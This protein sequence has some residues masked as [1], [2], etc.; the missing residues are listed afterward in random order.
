MSLRPGELTLVAAELTRELQQSVI[1]KVH[2]PTT[3]RVY[4]ELRVPG[5][6]VTLL[7]CSEPNVARVSAVV[8][9]PANPATP[10]AWQ[11]VLR[12][13]LLGVKFRD[14]EALPGRRTLL[15]HVTREGDVP[16][17]RTLVLEL[18]ATPGIALITET[19]RILA[20]SIPFR[21][22][23]RIGATWLVADEQP[24][25]EAPSR[26]A[27][28]QV[29]LRLT[30]AAETLYATKEQQT[31]D[32]ARRAPLVA[33]LKRLARTREKVKAEA[34]RAEQAAKLRSE[35]ELLTHNLFKVVRGQKSVTLTE[36]LPDGSMREVEIVL[37]PKR[38]PKE[39]VEWRF[40]QYRR[41][42]RGAD[43][44]A[45]RLAVLD[46]EEQRLRAEL[47]QLSNEQAAMP[48]PAERKEK[49][50]SAQAPL[51]PYREY[52][53]QGAQRIWVGRGA[54]HNDSLTFHVA[55]PFHMWFHARGV[56]GAHVVVPLD[57]NA[58]MSAETLLDAAHLALHHSDAK[59]EPRGEVSYTQV[60]FVRKA[61]AP[62]A[63][64]YTREKTINLRVEE[65]RLQR[66][67]R[68]E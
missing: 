11:S 66:L 18:S 65:D 16:V 12:R 37:D 21:T 40:H 13:E 41:L 46:E 3:T 58:S 63:V 17:H 64:T 8:E 31:W 39:E 55:R 49:G 14:V 19:G 27:G 29:F 1:Q 32:D 45:A 30:H 20:M 33:K 68:S 25:K 47:E 5:R 15:L 23:F 10:P 38:T 60:K 56:P 51:P 44:A 53:G 50:A 48:P 54:V 59:G 61:G 36:Y 43:I 67:L 42:L 4:L 62:G 9:R 2:A 57:K 28:D 35:G 52:T 7:F 22:G 34:N 26:L 24:V 6:S